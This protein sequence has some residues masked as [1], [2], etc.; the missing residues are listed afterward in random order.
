MS[1]VETRAKA[2]RPRDPH[3]DEAIVTAVLE[4]LATEGYAQLSVERIAAHAGVGKAS[5]YRRWPD[6]ISIVLEAVSRNP[7]RPSAPDTG[8]LREDML[9]YLSTLV[10]Y[11]SVHAEAIAAISGEALRDAFFAQAF[12]VGMTG[13]VIADLR[14]IT[15]RAVARGELPAGTDTALLASLVPALLQMERLLSGHHPDEVFVGRIV[16]QFFTP[17]GESVVDGG[18]RAPVAA[19]GDTKEGESL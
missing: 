13:P 17:G 5:L 6:K 8:S 9:E 2:G 10:Q 11:R 16:D 18:R 12:R 1:V 3:V 4:L 7:E 19:P 15:E 14:A